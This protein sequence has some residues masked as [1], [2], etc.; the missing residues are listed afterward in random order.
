MLNSFHK[1]LILLKLV[2]NPEYENTK[3]YEVTSIT[4]KTF[5]STVELR[6]S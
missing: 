4:H 1:S 2:L 6:G 3:Y 5:L